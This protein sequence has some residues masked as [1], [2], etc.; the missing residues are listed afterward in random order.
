MHLGV[1]EDNCG[2]C[3]LDAIH[4]HNKDTEK[5]MQKA[6][7]EHV[8]D[9]IAEHFPS[10]KTPRK[11]SVLKPG[12]C[13]CVKQ[14]LYAKELGAVTIPHVEPPRYLSKYEQDQY[15]SHLS[16][17]LL[18]EWKYTLSPLD[19]GLIGVPMMATAFSGAPVQ[20]AMQYSTRSR[21]RPPI[22]ELKDTIYGAV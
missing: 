11:N 15:N 7:R 13:S 20:L 12:D 14:P 4:K 16:R 9:L 6:E 2:A 21:L 3:W 1:P 17:E 8:S 5:E 10:E 22:K 18:K 19:D